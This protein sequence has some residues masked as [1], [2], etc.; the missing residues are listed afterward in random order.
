MPAYLAQGWF[1]LVAA[2]LLH[3]ILHRSMHAAELYPHVDSMHAAELY[4]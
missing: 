1:E 3:S 2:L 4:S